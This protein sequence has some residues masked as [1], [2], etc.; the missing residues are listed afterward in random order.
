M[1]D[2]TEFFFIDN[3]IINNI[4]N[5]TERLRF[6]MNENLLEKR[7]EPI[8]KFELFAK[9]RNF[10]KIYSLIDMQN[11]EMIINTCRLINFS[12][13]VELFSQNM[14]TWINKGYTILFFK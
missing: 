12:N 4:E 14:E 7:N 6:L 10:L 2:E 13:N 9:K 3:M 11:Y 1:S 8:A 5:T